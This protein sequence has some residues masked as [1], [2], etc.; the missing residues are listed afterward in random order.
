MRDSRRYRRLECKLIAILTV[1]SGVP[2]VSA[3][4]APKNAKESPDKAPAEDR[5]GQELKRL[6]MYA[7]SWSVTERH[8]DA[9]GE[10]VATVKGTE[11]VTWL[12]SGTALRRAYSTDAATSTYH[13]LGTI[14]WND[15]E[16]K[17]HGVWFDDVSTGGPTI[18]KGDWN[19]ETRTMTMRNERSGPAEKPLVYNVIEKFLD[20]EN[21]VATTYRVD[22]STITKLLEVQYKRIECPSTNSL[23]GIFDG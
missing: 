17:Y 8:F 14:T 7:G 23:R 15:V 13:A 2:I 20:D 22:G 18:S 4:D 6:Q 9:Q 16:K 5:R 1:V 11:N 12:L 10:V 21:R 19:E 3:Q